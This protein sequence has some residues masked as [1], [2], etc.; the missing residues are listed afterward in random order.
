[1]SSCILSLRSFWAFFFEDEDADDS[2]DLSKGAGAD[3]ANRFPSI[4]AEKFLLLTTNNNNLQLISKKY[5][6]QCGTIIQ[7][8]I[9]FNFIGQYA[10]P[11]KDFLGRLAYIN[12]VIFIMQSYYELQSIFKHINEFSF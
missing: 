10:N 8:R 3:K 11:P 4:F 1:M 12:S 5:L 7:N 2:V 9:V 6:F